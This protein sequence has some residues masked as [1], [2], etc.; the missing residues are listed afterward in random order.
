MKKTILI[1]K[2]EAGV[3]VEECVPVLIETTGA[4]PSD[5]MRHSDRRR[6]ENANLVT[7]LLT[8]M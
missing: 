1:L 4:A 8:K 6:I 7:H 5:A 2:G 3:D